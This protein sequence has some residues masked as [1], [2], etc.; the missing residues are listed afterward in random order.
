MELASALSFVVVFRLFFDILPAGDA[1]A[2]A[3]TAEGSG[4]LLP[5][6]G[7]GGLAV[8]GCWPTDGAPVSW[9]VRRSAGLFFL[10]A[11]VS[12]AALV[13]SGLALIA[14]APAGTSYGWCCRR[15]PAPQ[16]F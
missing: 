1:R 2:L 12:G 3:W 14:G 10:G 5:L 11:A 4:A 13:S 6:G 16:R 7:A 9:I 8:G 15:R